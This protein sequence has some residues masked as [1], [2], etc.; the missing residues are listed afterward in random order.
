[1]NTTDLGLR[2]A[3]K[4]IPQDVPSYKKLNEKALDLDG[5]DS[6]GDTME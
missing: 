2:K 3:I 6:A 4:R 5:E 1:M